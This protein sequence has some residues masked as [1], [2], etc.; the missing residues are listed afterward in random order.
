MV[1]SE[2]PSRKVSRKGPSYTR[3][4]PAKLCR[5]SRPNP[6]AAWYLATEGW[7]GPMVLSRNQR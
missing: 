7:V 1:D 6:R 4:V 5:P 2:G 3:K